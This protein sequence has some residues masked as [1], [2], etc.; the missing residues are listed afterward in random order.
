MAPAPQSQFPTLIVME[1]LHSLLESYRHVPNAY[2]DDVRAAT[3][4]EIEK[5]RRYQTQMQSLPATASTIFTQVI[6][7]LITG[8]G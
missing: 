8:R 5:L 3:I 6:M 7:P 4:A 2:P 1:R